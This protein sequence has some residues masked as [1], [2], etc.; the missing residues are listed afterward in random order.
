MDEGQP[1]RRPTRNVP[2]V[3]SSDAKPT[4]VP[5]HTEVVAVEGEKASRTEPIA[6]GRA[7]QPKLE[8][9]AAE[10]K[11]T[12]ALLDDF[13]SKLAP[14]SEDKSNKVPTAPDAVL[15][16]SNDLPPSSPS[17]TQ[18][19][20]LPAD[21]L[22]VGPAHSDSVDLF[23]GT[24]ADPFDDDELPPT[25]RESTRP[26]ATAVSPVPEPPEAEPALR[27]RSKTTVPATTAEPATQ[28]SKVPAKVPVIASGGGR[29]PS[30][31]IRAATSASP[32]DARRSEPGPRPASRSSGKLVAEGPR[33]EE[34]RATG[35][36]PTRSM[37]AVTADGTTLLPVPESEGRPSRAGPTPS[38]A[39]AVQETHLLPIPDEE[40]SDPSRPP[41]AASEPTNLFPLPRAGNA[42]G[43]GVPRRA[44]AEIPA[45]RGKHAAARAETAERK[46]RGRGFVESFTHMMLIGPVTHMQKVWAG[47][48]PRTKIV[49]GAL[50]VLAFVVFFV[51]LA[52]GVVALLDDRPNSDELIAAYPYG[53]AGQKGTR[54]IDAPPAARATFTLEG[55]RPCGGTSAEMCLQYRY[56]GPNRFTGY[57]LLHKVNGHWQRFGL[58]GAPFEPERR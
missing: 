17:D 20:P 52:L 5:E 44:S 11:Q 43:P 45:P 29:A 7:S 51:L 37:P 18:Q 3:A 41:P 32:P 46:P 31:E 6:R 30:R 40:A 36:P 13:Y 12:E 48:P 49:A 39:I 38:L 54:G 28:P 53:Y 27:T 23:V 16:W 57:M 22:I 42:P 33:A 21:D 47:W 8:L 25:P 19:N 55:Q 34:P 58:E 15:P 2:A 26:D 50:G 10:R 9:T 24:I 4:A 56:D 1:K 35:R 14:S